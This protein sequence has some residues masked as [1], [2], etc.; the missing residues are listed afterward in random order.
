LLLAESIP[1]PSPGGPIPIPYP[2][3]ELPDKNAKAKKT[4]GDPMPAQKKKSFGSEPAPGGGRPA[5]S[6]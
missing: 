1:A 4:T 5:Q 6:R 3:T 2:N